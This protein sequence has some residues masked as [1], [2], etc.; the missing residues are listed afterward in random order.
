MELWN[1]IHRDR[2]LVFVAK[3][4]IADHPSSRARFLA[5]RFDRLGGGYALKD[6]YKVESLRVGR[7]APNNTNAAN[8]LTMLPFYDI[9]WE[10]LTQSF[11]C[12]Q[13]IR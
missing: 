4:Q 8:G 12:H 6:Y 5:N 2:C 9:T 7:S 10:I 3:S 1:R 13:H 11:L